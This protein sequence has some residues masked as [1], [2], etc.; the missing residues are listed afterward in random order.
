MS[1][2]NPTEAARAVVINVL[3]WL[4]LNDPDSVAAVNAADG[5][6]VEVRVSFWRIRAGLGMPQGLELAKMMT[7]IHALPV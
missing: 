3:D 1:D 2:H 7:H 4:S 6:V 5:G